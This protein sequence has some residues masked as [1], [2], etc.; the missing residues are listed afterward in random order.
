MKTNCNSNSFAVVLLLLFFFF[1]VVSKLMTAERGELGK[2]LK[3][4]DEG[5]GS[6]F[7]SA[8]VLIF[9]SEESKTWYENASITD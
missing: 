3:V 5:R 6:F 2:V 4:P 1:R 8:F 9:C 7:L